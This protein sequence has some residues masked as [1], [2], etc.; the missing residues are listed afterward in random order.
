MVRRLFSEHVGL[1]VI[2]MLV[3]VGALWLHSAVTDALRRRRRVASLY[4]CERCGRVYEDERNV[5]L[6][7]CP[8]CGA[9]NEAIQR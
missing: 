8:G 2:G 6:S 1:W 9:L 5:P 4:R 3:A 7:A